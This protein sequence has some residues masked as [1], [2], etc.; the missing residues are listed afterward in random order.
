MRPF[1]IGIEM[2]NPGG[3]PLTRRRRLVALSRHTDTPR[4][5][6]LELNPE[7][8][9]YLPVVDGEDAFES[10]WEPLRMVLEDAPQKLTRQDSL[11]E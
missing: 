5:L 4:R 10:C 6:L 3:D 1:K 7:G 2:Q 8:S 9:D 11:A